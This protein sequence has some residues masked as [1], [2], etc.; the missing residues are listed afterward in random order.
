MT[1]SNEI[2]RLIA[3]R[4]GKSMECLATGE[5]ERALLALHGALG[6]L[7]HLGRALSSEDTARLARLCEAVSVLGMDEVQL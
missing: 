7:Q 4:I 2:T 3:R 1:S 6:A 5:R